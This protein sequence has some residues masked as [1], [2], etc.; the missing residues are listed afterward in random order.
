MTAFRLAPIVLAAVCIG[1]EAAT[2]PSGAPADAKPLSERIEDGVTGLGYSEKVAA[3]FVR[4]VAAWKTEDGRAVVA[5]W[6]ATLDL[7]RRRMGEGALSREKVVE[8]EV[9]IARRL[10][11][12]IGKEIVHRWEKGFSHLP[13]VMKHRK[14]RS[15][16]YAQMFYILGR[17]VGLSVEALELSY[18]IPGRQPGNEGDTACVVRLADAKV[19]IAD[20][21]F[22]PM[23]SKPFELGS[24]Y[25]Q[26]GNYLE[27]AAA[28]NVASMHRRI[29][30]LDKSGLVSRI[31]TSRGN[32]ASSAGRHA[33]AL[34]YHAKALA[35]DPVSAG[36]YRARGCTLRDLGKYAEAM[37]DFKKAVDLDPQRASV[38]LDI[39]YCCWLQGDA[40][41]ARANYA[42]ATTLH[43]W[44]AEPYYGLGV[45]CSEARDFRQAVVNYSKAIELDPEYT[46][47]YVSRGGAYRLLGE[48]RKALVDFDTAL[49]LDPKNADAYHGRGMSYEAYGW[50]SAAI[51]DYSKAIALNPN[52]PHMY[53]QRAHARLGAGSCEGEDGARILDDLKQAIK[54]K[55][56]FKTAYALRAD[57]FIHT[58]APDLAIRA[59][60]TAIK[61]DPKYAHAYSKRGIAYYLCNDF[62]RAI[63]DYS[64]AI[65]LDPGTTNA[66][67]HRGFAYFET[68]QYEKAI[69]DF[70]TA[71]ERNAKNDEL[72]YKRGIAYAELGKR[73]QAAQDLAEAVRVN[74][75]CAN[76]VEAAA[77]KYRLD[78][79]Y[80]D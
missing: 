64:K 26:V 70:T 68:R 72:Y 49:K 47:A 74:P 43:P 54:L 39:A 22:E 48:Y 3:D 7:A 55:P 57:F 59:L 18:P 11:T 2:P 23:V 66:H 25:R 60:D 73:E 65:E 20:V 4:M 40:K 79:R 80:D 19:V 53:Y 56:D 51:K 5:V 30:L 24:A 36:A 45:I 44:Y 1:A 63:A 38:Y 61:L 12:R 77:R 32:F 13:D 41:A 71:C 52:N 67:L 27:L 17:S 31:C 33:Q 78:V 15:L 10:T 29:R 9:G 50:A 34:Q 37:A 8:L 62:A 76:L 6:N 75:G 35:L 21:A 42:K 69:A 28:G 46:F 14:T 16:G 58:K